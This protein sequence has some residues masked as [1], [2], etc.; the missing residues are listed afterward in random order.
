MTLLTPLGLLGLIG[1]LILII[2]YIIKPNYQQKFI[3]TTYVWK[4]SLKYRKKK[5]PMSKLRNILLIICQVLILTICATILAE[6]AKVL[7]QP[8]LEREVIAI[9]DSSASM[10][11][12]W[13]DKTRFERAV[14][15][16]SALSEEVFAEGGKVSIILGDNAPR[17]L[18]ERVTAENKEVVADVLQPLLVSTSMRNTA[19]A[20]GES[21][22]NAALD[23]CESI[24]QD[25]PDAEIHLYTDTTYFYV[26]EGVSL[27]ITNVADERE[28]NAAILDAY[29]EKNNAGYYTFVVD[30]ACYAPQSVEL[31]V[32]ITVNN[33]NSQ[34]KEDVGGGV[35]IKLASSELAEQRIYCENEVTKRVIFINSDLYQKNEEE[36][37]DVIYCLIPMA[38]RIFSFNSVHISVAEAEGDVDC[39]AEDNNFNIYG[40][41]KEILK[42]QYA[43][44]SPNNFVDGVLLTLQK[45]LSD[46]WNLK[47]TVVKQNEP[48]AIKGFDVYVFEHDAMPEEMPRDG[49]VILINPSKD[50]SLA[51]LR[52]GE[53]YPIEQGEEVKYGLTQDVDK[54][55][56]LNRVDASK[57]NITLNKAITHDGSYESLLSYGGVSTLLVKDAPKEKVVVFPFRLHYSNLPIRLE[58]PMLF[59]NIF[60]YFLPTMVEGNAFS[61]GENVEL[62]SR[63]DSLE[64]T[65][66]DGV[67]PA[68]VFTEFPAYFKADVPGTYNLEQLTF[69]N[70]TILERIY[71]KIPAVES[72]IRRVEDTLEVPYVAVDKSD[73]FDDLLVYFAAA[74]VALVFIEW[75]LQSRD[76][77]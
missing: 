24:L 55:P 52:V 4:L 56:I 60:T 13:E 39:F 54:H 49:I 12:T 44:T 11:T 68:Q 23:M 26:P 33:A 75:W 70:K 18:A 29:V 27:E 1:I 6:P 73:Y 22:I 20:Y 51:G 16:V 50:F 36:S 5:I 7:K 17:Y 9:I 2:I 69:A 53:A 67:V 30:V 71:V 77:V 62:N 28:W 58:F 66:K 38:D 76:N 37:E 32:D 21:D 72:N 43:S 15:E 57:I 64:V 8:I 40:G 10:L 14:K 19:C 41:Q 45:I 63:C 65:H 25:N 34:D 47:L 59:Y 61:V 42:V 31:E 46:S 35:T 74:L 3:S 48:F